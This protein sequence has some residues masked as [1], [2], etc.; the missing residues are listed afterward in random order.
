[1]SLSDNIKIV[2]LAQAIIKLQTGLGKAYNK[3]RNFR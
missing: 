1:V 3:K 2:K